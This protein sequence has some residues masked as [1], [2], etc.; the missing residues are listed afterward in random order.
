MKIE[1]SIKV[2]YLPDWRAW[3]GLREL[4]QNARDAR[5]EHGASLKVDHKGKVL[6]ICSEGAILSHRDLLLGQTSKFGNADLAGKFGEGLKLGVLA[7]VRDGHTV[8]IRT[9]GEIWTPAIQKSDTFGEDVLVFQIRKTP[10]YTEAVCIEIGDVDKETGDTLR[11][12]LLFLTETAPD[13][14]IETSYG[15]LLL[16]MQHTGM[17]FVKGIYVGHDIEILYGYDLKDAEVD[18]DRKMINQWDQK[19]RLRMI[20]QEALGRRPDLLDKFNHLLTTQK[21]D[22]AGIDEYAAG[23]LPEA[24]QQHVVQQFQAQFGEDAVPVSSLSESAEVEHLGKKGVVVPKGLGAVL[25]KVLGHTAEQKEKLRKET[26]KQYSWHDLEQAERDN[27]TSAIKLVCFAVPISLAEVDV[28]D[29]RDEKIMG[30]RKGTRTQVAKKHLADPDLTLEI[31]VHETAHAGGAGDG[32][33]DHVATVEAIW[34]KI[35]SALRKGAV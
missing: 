24:A 4:L 29:F 9:G 12:R 22:V 10:K 34:S 28:V 14:M 18:R 21:A 7:L 3:E 19:W 1:L 8:K 13:E 11:P 23:S 5:V 33:K 32:S 20:W 15:T 26:L 16:G 2:T 6:T 27:L 35:V 30:L 25:S 31:L 17:L